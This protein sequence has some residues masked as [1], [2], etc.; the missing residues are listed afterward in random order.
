MLKSRMKIKLAAVVSPPAA[1]DA[2]PVGDA[3]TEIIFSQFPH[4]QHNSR[5]FGVSFLLSV[6]V[7]IAAGAVRVIVTDVWAGWV[8][9]SKKS[10]SISHPPVQVWYIVGNALLLTGGDGID[11]LLD[12]APFLIFTLGRRCGE[13]NSKKEEKNLGIHRLLTRCTLASW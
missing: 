10:I 1:L 3:A 9:M 2:K 6:P 7:A 13:G 4:T 12:E 5:L 11:D 8:K